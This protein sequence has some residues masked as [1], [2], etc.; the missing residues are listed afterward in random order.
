ME[1]EKQK[2]MKNE[3][4][5]YDFRKNKAEKENISDEPVQKKPEPKKEQTPD[6]SI[7]DEQLSEEEN[8]VSSDD[9]GIV[10][11]KSQDNKIQ[12]DEVDKNFLK[13]YSTKFLDQPKTFNKQANK[14]NPNE[15]KPK[16]FKRL[17]TEEYEARVVNIS[18]LDL[19]DK[20]RFVTSP[21]PV[22]RIVQVSI[23]RD[24]SGLKNRFYP[25]YHVSFSVS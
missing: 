10:L 18:E 12:E 15:N 3:Q 8:S 5:K 4:S 16:T 7:T 20:T 14:T 22:G 21:P 9:E 11:T 17:T 6:N 1:I 19:D 25:K 23:F 2:N 24:R 13:K